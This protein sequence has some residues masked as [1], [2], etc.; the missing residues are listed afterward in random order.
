MTPRMWSALVL[1]IVAAIACSRAKESSQTSEPFT[2]SYVSH[3][4]SDSGQLIDAAVAPDGESV[5]TTFRLAL[6]PPALV[7]T[8]G[9]TIR[10]IMRRGEPGGTS[11]LLVMLGPAFYDFHPKPPPSGGLVAIDLSI[12]TTDSLPLLLTVRSPLR[13]GPWLAEAR[14]TN[15]GRFSVALDDRTKRGEF[16]R[17]DPVGDTRVFTAIAGLL[18]PR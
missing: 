11:Y 3:A 1:L 5:P 14:L 6:A 4:I 2:F 18:G 16:R 8:A 13:P 9:E 17:I 10:A 15:G 7:S 12:H